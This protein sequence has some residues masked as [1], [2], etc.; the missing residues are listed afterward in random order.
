MA[1]SPPV[2]AAA[3]AITIGH[4]VSPHPQFNQ[5]AHRHRGKL[6]MLPK[7]FN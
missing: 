2:R 7:P 4:L 3:R 5:A 6:L 1:T